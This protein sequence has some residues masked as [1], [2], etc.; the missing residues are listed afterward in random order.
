MRVVA[1]IDSVN[2][3]V[4]T[5]L[6]LAAVSMGGCAQIGQSP[7]NATDRQ[8]NLL[9][10]EIDAEGIK[11]TVDQDSD[12]PLTI[13]VTATHLCAVTEQQVLSRTT[14]IETQNQTPI[15]DWLALGAGAVVAGSGA[16][17]LVDA[18]SVHPHDDTSRQYNPVGPSNAR[19]IGGG[20]VAAGVALLAIPVVDAIRANQTTVDTQQ[21]TTSPT[22]VQRGIACKA[23]PYSGV[24]IKGVVGLRNWPI[25]KTGDDGTL[26]AHLQAIVPPDATWIAERFEM[27]VFADDQ[28]I[29]SVSLRKVFLERE[30]K[31]WKRVA[32]ACQTPT[33]ST[34][35]R[36]VD[37]FLKLFP[38]G[39]H[40]AEARRVMDQ[41]KPKLEELSADEDWGKLQLESCATKS[42]EETL[43]SLEVACF[44]LEQYVQN[45]PQSVHTGKVRE[46][47][48]KG[49]SRLAKLREAEEKRLERESRKEQMALDAEAK[50]ARE[51]AAAEA[52]RQQEAERREAER[53]RAQCRAQCQMGCSSWQFRHNPAACVSAC[54]QARCQQ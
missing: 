15:V 38:G 39:P 30:S 47:L 4:L 40:E 21:V 34:A 33:S 14:T 50:R 46:A 8:L 9:R 43:E 31:T 1:C 19:A 12:A 25:G 3:P 41:A 36:P 51:A 26:E 49:Q 27:K 48:N 17:V 35:C 28:E 54:V 53:E 44:P 18:N 5:A 16:A 45:H 7:P 52:R 20:L 29:G 10:R 37:D 23:R 42:K 32:P 22:I 2:R 13:R 11:A 24:T 6:A